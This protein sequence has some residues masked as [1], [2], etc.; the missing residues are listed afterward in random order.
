M[1]WGDK[2]QVVIPDP[3]PVPFDS[4][5][6]KPGD[7]VWVEWY[8]GAIS[9]WQT[10]KCFYDH[11]NRHN[12]DDIEV[13]PGYWFDREGYLGGNHEKPNARLF[14]KEPKK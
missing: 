11:P 2:I 1:F 8:N 9:C 7:K 14:F 5:K 6:V 12:P 13:T 4:R 3:G 10:V